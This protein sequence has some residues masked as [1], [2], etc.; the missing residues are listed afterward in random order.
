TSRTRGIVRVQNPTSG[1]PSV[2]TFATGTIFDGLAFAGDGSVL[3]VARSPSIVGFDRTGAEVL[4]I[5]TGHPTDGVAIAQ[6][7]AVIG[8][9]DVSNNLF[10]NCN[11]GVLLRIDVNNGNA[12]SVVAS[13]GSRG[14]FVTVGP[15]GCLYATQSDRIVKL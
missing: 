3:Y 2:D 10:V 7:N 15:D 1:S 5:N 4:N 13:G 14:D 9:I 11:D 6:S 12:V 8:G